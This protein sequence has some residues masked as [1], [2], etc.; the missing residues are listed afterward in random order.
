MDPQTLKTKTIGVLM[1]GLSGE[2][3]VSFRSGENCLRALE[4]RGY[5]VVRVDAVRDVAERIDEEG[6]EVAFL[7]LHG[8]YGE[9][10]TVQ[11]LLEVMGIPYTGS[12][13]LASAL[14]MN[15]IAAKK[16]VRA[17]G[18]PTPDYVEIN[19]GE[20]AA[21]AAARIEAEL[22]L[23]VM[24]KP[25][26]VGSSLGVF[27]CKSAGDLRASVERGREKYGAMFAERFVSGTEITVGVLE[28]DGCPQALPILELVPKNEFYDYEAK[29]T[30]GM[31][32]F[33]LPARLAP[34]AYAAAEDAAVA[35]FAAIGCRGYARV[36]IMVDGAG[37]P[38]FVEVNTLPGMTD[39]SDLPAQAL[40][41]G[42]S[43][44]ELVET[45]LLTAVA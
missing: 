28:R 4:A 25:V 8:R 43:Y 21:S 19:G 41:A 36:D 20:P 37:V 22:D 12:G 5:R 27:K 9:D 3:E 2:R 42:I 33:V 17:S 35:A 38:W 30:E 26:E 32:E 15:K 16:V 40:A 34:A 24:L 31:T 29:Y 14:G 1:G 45:I 11:G 18:L 44:E 10:G 23:P 6:V 39:T 13:V 7:A